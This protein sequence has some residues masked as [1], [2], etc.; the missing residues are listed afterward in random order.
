MELRLVS[1]DEEMPT[2]FGD[3]FQKREIQFKNHFNERF[4]VDMVNIDNIQYYWQNID[5]NLLNYC[6]TELEYLEL[7]LCK[8][9][10]YNF[11]TNVRNRLMCLINARFKH[12]ILKFFSGKHVLLQHLHLKKLK[13]SLNRWKK[14]LAE[15][16]RSH[17]F[18]LTTSF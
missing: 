13:T 9:M 11:T 12:V 2:N 4:P 6:Q 18:M 5:K 14:F 10:C 8:F 7:I 15:I 17:S 3:E 1:N 16:N